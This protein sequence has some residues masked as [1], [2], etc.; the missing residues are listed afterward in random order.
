LPTRRIVPP[1]RSEKKPLTRVGR[2]NVAQRQN[3][4]FARGR[5]PR[6][7]CANSDRDEEASAMNLPLGETYNYGPRFL[8]TSSI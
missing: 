4:P 2:Y 8:L 1:N 3:L 6:D 7:G 5:P